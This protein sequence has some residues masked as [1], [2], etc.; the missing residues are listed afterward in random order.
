MGRIKERIL[1]VVVEICASN[2]Y[3]PTDAANQLI[4]RTVRRRQFRHLCGHIPF[5]PLAPARQAQTPNRNLNYHPH[6][7]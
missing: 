4:A 6:N 3:N 1:V 5:F 2:I 7:I